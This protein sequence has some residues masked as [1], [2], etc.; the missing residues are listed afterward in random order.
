LVSENLTPTTG[1]KAETSKVE[2]NITNNLPKIIG[3]LALI[4]A[5]IMIAVV[6]TRTSMKK[7]R[8]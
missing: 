6:V 8:K 4:L 2:T 7:N 3:V 1:D 5:L